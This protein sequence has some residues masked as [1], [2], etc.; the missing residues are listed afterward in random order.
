MKDL[1]FQILDNSYQDFILD[2]GDELYLHE[3][4]ESEEIQ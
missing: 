1:E 4:S 3:Q 2:L